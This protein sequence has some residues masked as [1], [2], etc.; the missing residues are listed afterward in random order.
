[1]V[2]TATVA[3]PIAIP[4]QTVAQV[5]QALA[6][7]T[8]VD[9]AIAQG[10]IQGAT[11]AAKALST[12][13]TGA[14]SSISQS[15]PIIGAAFSAIASILIAQSQAR[16]KA[17]QSENTAVA[18][19]VPGWDSAVATVIAEYN[20][21]AN[22]GLSVSQAQALLQTVMGN[23]WNEVTPQIQSGR[24]GCRSG[25]NC[26]PSSNPSSSMSYNA[27]GNNYCSGDIGAACCVGC[28]DL[29]LSMDNINWALLQSAKTGMPQTAF[30]QV[31]D[32]S[33]YGGVNRPAYT[34]SIVPPAIPAV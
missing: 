2:A 34:V 8:Q 9:T 31:V 11:V 26:P 28:A 13:L 16:A 24:N 17:A 23:Y 5:N 15:I 19:G 21:Q 22:G 32:A 25:A 27:G 30:V 3:A 10:T 4:P 7:Q 12:S 33:K 29:Q 1:P 14:T 18:A 20:T 6:G